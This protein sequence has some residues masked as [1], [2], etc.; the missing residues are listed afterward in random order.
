MRRT[1]LKAGSEMLTGR[2][3]HQEMLKA[4]LLA[5]FCLARSATIA[6]CLPSLI[7]LYLPWCCP[8]FWLSAL[9]LLARALPRLLWFL[10]L[11]NEESLDTMA[12]ASATTFGA[13][14][15]RAVA[16]GNG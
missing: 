3:V 6:P 15:F 10:A 11:L 12:S 13:A 9:S 14:V 7:T 16:A 8:A 5:L 4:A 1:I 2:F